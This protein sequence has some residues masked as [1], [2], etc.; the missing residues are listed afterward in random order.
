M[1]VETYK[2]IFSNSN[3]LPKEIYQE[4]LSHFIDFLNQQRVLF[5]SDGAVLYELVYDDKY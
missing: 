5:Q 3:I 4:R 1:F 2:N